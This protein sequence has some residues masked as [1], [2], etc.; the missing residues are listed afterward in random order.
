MS[1]ATPPV[2]TT[3]VK[4][5]PSGSLTCPPEEQTTIVT[6]S[7]RYK[8][9]D[10]FTDTITLTQCV[11]GTSTKPESIISTSVPGSSIPGSS[12]PTSSVDST[13][14]YFSTSQNFILN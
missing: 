6:T 12:V 4:P 2:T 9:G 7:T 5:T 3:K 10:C 13:S 14:E 8:G 11:P 1:T